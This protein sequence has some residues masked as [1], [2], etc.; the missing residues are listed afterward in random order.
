MTPK[1]R[2]WFVVNVSLVA[3]FFGFALWG[4][5]QVSYG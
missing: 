5:L 2:F 1:E 4:V 3:G